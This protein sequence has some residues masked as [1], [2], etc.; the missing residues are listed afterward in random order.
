MSVHIRTSYIPLYAR[1]L[2]EHTAQRLTDRAA[3]VGG[4]RQLQQRL[5]EITH[6]ARIQSAARAD[7]LRLFDSNTYKQLQLV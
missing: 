6:H 5:E 1:Y 7:I 3:H 4:K 2:L